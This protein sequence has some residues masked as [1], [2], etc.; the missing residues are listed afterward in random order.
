[1]LNKSLKYQEIINLI[2]INKFQEAKILLNNL[3]QTYKSSFNF[4]Y[5][6]G[7]IFHNMNELDDARIFYLR[8]LELE[9]ENEEVN[10]NLAILNYKQK[11]YLES[12]NLFN[13]LISIN[14]DNSIYYYNLGIIKIE[15]NEI[16]S[17]IN[18]FSK[19]CN[20][21]DNF[22]FA[23]HHLAEAYE[24][25]NNLNLA[26]LN[27]N[28]A[29]SININRFNN[30]L[31]NLGNIYLKLKDFASAEKY[32]TQ[33]L[34]Y[35]GDK[36]YVFNNLA[37]LHLEIG[38]VDVALDFLYRAIS[39]NKNDLR[40]FSRFLATSLYLK[41]DINYYKDF[42]IEYGEI[43]NSKVKNKIF[44]KINVNKNKKLKIGFVSADFREHPVG[45]YLLDFLKEIKNYDFL[46]TAYSNNLFE[47]YYT[48]LLKLD[49]DEWRDINHLNDENLA[50]LIKKDSVDILIDMSGHSGDN[51][52]PIFSY[53]PALMQLSWAAYLAS[54]GM[55]EIDYIIGDRHCTPYSDSKNYVEKII[56]LPD[57]WSCLSTS[58][59]KNIPI[60]TTPALKNNYITFGCFNNL[61]KINKNLINIWSKI[62]KQIPNSKIF[63]KNSQFS[64]DIN[65][66][67]ILTTFEENK[68]EPERIIIKSDSPRNKFLNNYNYVDIALDTFPYNGGTTS[69]ELSWMCVP[70]LT[71]KG[72]R[73][74]SKCGESI[75]NNLNMQ[76]WIADNEEDY[77]RKA[78]FFSKDINKLENIKKKL[79]MI[80]RKSSLFDM[81]K[82]T[83]NFANILRRAFENF[84]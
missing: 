18:L 71:I 30:T 83:N 76:D 36:S 8:A 7:L 19:A 40:I 54:T 34:D 43:S 11:R 72:D 77:I 32:F 58:D 25:A 14:P 65:K 61:N 35:M 78:I 82:Y 13:H 55:K 59:I 50:Y 68:I 62:L 47:D 27:Y 79:R 23:R 51:R 33:S 16:I 1:M 81:K 75:N 70:L 42:S 66:K 6:S 2:N 74:V 44:K 56:Q 3:D 60:T 20:L 45:Y 84:F 15:Q 10:F 38:N 52:L 63:L 53:K 4:Y 73:F 57:I 80:S 46:L 29:Q 26:I 49:Y 5:L 41:K 12:V 48:K 64:I 24:K 67:N 31:N 17:S 28:K 22:Y 69:F 21:D 9:P 39:L 37:A